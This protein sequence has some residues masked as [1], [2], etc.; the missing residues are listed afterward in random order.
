VFIEML[1]ALLTVSA[2][3]NRLCDGRNKRDRFAHFNDTYEYYVQVMWDSKQWVDQLGVAEDKTTPAKSIQD[4]C[5]VIKTDTDR[6]PIST[7]VEKI[8][9][10]TRNVFLPKLR[11]LLDS[12]GNIRSGQQKEDVREAIRLFYFAYVKMPRAKKS[13]NCDESEGDEHV[14]HVEKAMEQPKD[15]LHDPVKFQAAQD[16][17]H[18]PEMYVFFH[19]GPAVIGGQNNVFLLQNPADMQKALQASGGGGRQA[20]RDHGSADVHAEARGK[21]RRLVTT[22]LASA[23]FQACVCP[24]YS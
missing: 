1:C 7:V 14:E 21:K 16:R 5:C 9:R 23:L 17:F 10:L 19:Q 8:I 22:T 11:K 4:R 2:V 15:S 13:L 24:A 12:N 3:N 20:H 6:T 18:P